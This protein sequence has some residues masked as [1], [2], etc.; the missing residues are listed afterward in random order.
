MRWL[1]GSH[2]L[3]GL[4]LLRK[5]GRSG[6]LHRPW[7]AAGKHSWLELAQPWALGAQLLEKWAECLCAASGKRS[8]ALSAQLSFLRSASSLHLL[9]PQHRPARRLCWRKQALARAPSVAFCFSLAGLAAP[10]HPPGPKLVA[11]Q[12]AAPWAAP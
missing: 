9:R 8:S 2:E 1:A 7:G 6:L 4:A 5:A 10:S 3:G 11:P 12:P